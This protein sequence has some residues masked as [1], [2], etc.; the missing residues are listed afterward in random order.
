VKIQDEIIHKLI[1]KK[2]FSYYPEDKYL[3]KKIMSL[4]E[5]KNPKVL[6][7]GCGIGHYSFLFE[8]Y[9]GHVIS[10]DYDK[11]VIEKAD[12]TKKKIDS[13]IKFMIAD[14]NYPEKYFNQKKFDIIFLSGFSLFGAQLNEELMKKYL[15]LLHNNG[16][17]IFIQNS[18][19]KG[20]I[21]KTHWKNYTIKSLLLFFEN[22]NCNIEK[23]FFYDR[24]IISRFLH[25]FVFNNFST[26]IH[27]II[28]KISRLPCNIVIV[29]S[30]K[31]L[32]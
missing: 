29:V 15:S 8:K 31:V 16:K 10:F 27:I 2:G 23:I 13:T 1:L 9:G 17:L 12:I 32:E 5:S 22:L 25:S 28:S 14:G 20:D 26:K 24:H 7:V 21:R 19:L 30:K 18:N 4:S 11:T 6:D 3:V